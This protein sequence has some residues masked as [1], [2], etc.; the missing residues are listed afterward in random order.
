MQRLLVLALCYACAGSAAVAAPAAPALA[1]ELP[2]WVQAPNDSARFRRFTLDNGMR[3]LLVSDPRFNKSAAALAVNT[4]SNDDPL[5]HQ[6]LAHFLEHMLFLGTEKYPDVSDFDNFLGSN[7]G[8]NNAYTA[9]DHTNYQIEVRHEAFAGALDRFAQFFIA[10]AFNADFTS[11]EV[12]AV[13]NEAMRHVQNDSRRLTAVVR[14]LYQAG[15]VEAKFSIGNK[16]TLARATPDV[17]RSFYRRHYSAQRMALA[18]AGTASLDELEKLARQLF[19]A[20]P[21]HALSDTGVDAAFLPRKNALRLAQIEPVKEVRQLN[22]EFVLP[23]TRPD[24]ASKPDQLLTELIAYP[25]PGGLVTSLKQEG[26]IN[27]LSADIW[28]R[29]GS[30]G[31]LMLQ[32][33]LTPAGQPQYRHV[34]QQ[35]LGYLAFLRSAEFPAAFY[36]DHARVAA[37][38]ETYKDR[39]EG[40]ELATRLANQ[41]LFYPLEVAERAG[42]VWG[43]PSEPAY[44]KLLAA[45]EP[46]NLL[47]TLM[48]KGVP[49]Q[50]RE[51]YYDIGYS[52]SEDA[53]AA[54][55]ALTQAPGPGTFTLPGSNRFMPGSVALLAERP[56]ALIDEPGLALYYAQDTE[57]QRPQ[58]SLVF[59]FVPARAVASA[60]SS[61]LLQLFDLCL[62]DF[63]EPALGDA[64]TAG[65]DFNAEVSLEGIKFSITG[66]GDSP[67]RLASYLASQL[68][69]F[70]CAPQRFDAL[71]EAML[72]GLRSYDQTE[73]F[74]LAGDRR[75]A[76]SREFYY[77]PSEQVSATAAATWPSVRA[78]ARSFMDQGKLEAVVHGHLTPEAAVGVTRAMAAGFASKGVAETA[79]L[80]RRHLE[81]APG[82]NVQD[83]GAIAGVNSAFV[84]DYLLPQDSPATLASAVLL[85]NFFGDA[86]YSELRTKQQLGYIVGSAAS[87]SVRQRYFCFIVQS[88]DYAPAELRARAEAFIATLPALLAASSAE[89]WDTLVAGARSTLAAKPKNMGEKAERFFALAYTYGGDWQRRQATLDALDQL[90][91]AQAAALL[92]A[93]LDP[94]RARQRSVLLASQKHASGDSGAPSLPERNAWKATRTFR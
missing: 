31:S 17:V 60:D 8:Y 93:V 27:A 40:A 75:D 92:A 4:G 73:A 25:G 6:G 28:E 32:L 3:V 18:L 50:R 37:I 2:A 64:Q 26:L 41:A 12:S 52:Y 88:S 72:R 29:T 16:D 43:K 5:E 81:I 77:L 9:S 11:R 82:E 21:R 70:T 59:R 63:L 58:S 54:F 47:V 68:R 55:A 45:L 94:A 91:Q 24:F 62:R 13:N 66:F 23:A 87:A 22:L 48:A 20:V 57:F 38:N 69:S 1:A 53:G 90:T 61:A 65:L 80:R 89:Q 71:K 44:R 33:S 67:V 46:D 49:V 86:F 15:S 51:R 56:L 78:L 19:A 79:L 42:D 14:E 7:G 74:K 35:V 39:G 34:L 85:A 10:P 30:Y 83:G 36:Q 76:L 84:R